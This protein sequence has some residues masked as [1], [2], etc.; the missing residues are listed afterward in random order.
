MKAFL[1]LLILSL[2]TPLMAGPRVVGNGGGGIK[3][4][5]VYKTFYSAG[6]YVNPE[7]EA[8]IPGA[9]LY[10]QTVLSLAGEGASTSQLLSSALPLGDRKF[11]KILEDKMD[12]TVMDRLLEEYARVVKQPT[13]DLTIFAI[14]DIGSKITYLLPS[15][16]K[17]S[18]TEQAAILFHEAYWI[19]NPQADYAEVVAAESSFQQFVELKQSGKFDLR[20]PRLLGKLLNDP[21]LPLKSAFSEDAKNQKIQNIIDSNG[22]IEIRYLFANDPSLCQSTLY[23]KFMRWSILN[24]EQFESRVKINCSLSNVNLESML[25]LVRKYPESFFFKELMNFIVTGNTVILN[26]DAIA[27]RWSSANDYTEKALKT[28]IDLTQISLSAKSI[29]INRNVLE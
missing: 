3:E 12:K 4:N 26:Q 20:L 28:K 18:E 8:D 29:V 1:L 17:L 13:A 5:G 16:Y 14:T 21:T 7:A 15:F 24:K 22:N 9:E 27:K 2:S 6:L 11:Y 25:I 23:Q 19:L 10:T